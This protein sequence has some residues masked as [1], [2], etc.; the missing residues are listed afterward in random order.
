M[1]RIL[2]YIQV[3]PMAAFY[4]PHLIADPTSP[5]VRD[6]ASNKLVRRGNFAAGRVYG[7]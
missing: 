4:E 3:I 6:A 1:V 2:T 5:F 7:R